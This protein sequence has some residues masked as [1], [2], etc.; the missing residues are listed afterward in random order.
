MEWR[1]IDPLGK[2][3]AEGHREFLIMD[4][5]G[6]IHVGF[7]V[8]DYYDSKYW[9]PIPKIPLADPVITNDAWVSLALKDING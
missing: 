8:F 7:N 4:E 3:E 1:T 9:C 6:S 2:F 5:F